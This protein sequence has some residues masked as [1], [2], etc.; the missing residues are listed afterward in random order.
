MIPVTNKINQVD[1]LTSHIF[2]IHFNIILPPMARSHTPER[3][4][5]ARLEGT[6]RREKT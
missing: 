2:K 4:Y 3:R 5:A 6:E 1:L